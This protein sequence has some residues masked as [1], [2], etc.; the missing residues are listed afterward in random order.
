MIP[1]SKDIHV[2]CM[3]ASRAATVAVC[4]EWGQQFGQSSP[5]NVPWVAQVE[6]KVGGQMEDARLVEGIIIDKDFSHPQVGP[7]DTHFRSP[8]LRVLGLQHLGVGVKGF[9]RHGLELWG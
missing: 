6:G 1:S 7:A 3:C 2:W 4:V 5:A 8:G 9:G